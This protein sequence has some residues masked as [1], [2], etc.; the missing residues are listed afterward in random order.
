MLENHVTFVEPPCEAAGAGQRRMID[1]S[2]T[3]EERPK[4]RPRL[5]SFPSFVERLSKFVLG[6]S[7]I[8]VYY[9]FKEAKSK[10]N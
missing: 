9:G 2:N 3:Q 5:A 4:K 6:L 7:A 1:V 10:F 8:R